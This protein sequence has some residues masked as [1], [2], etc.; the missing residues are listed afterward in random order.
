MRFWILL[1][2]LGWRLRWM[3]FRHK[4]FRQLVHGQDYTMQFRTADNR[5][6]RSYAFRQNRVKVRSGMHHD[7]TTVLTFR[8]ATYAFRTL[9]GMAKNP[10][11]FMEG[12]QKQDIRMTG[13]ASPWQ[14]FMAIL[15]F[16]PNRAQA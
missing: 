16:R 2:I 6:A 5:V 1:L 10:A 13:D 11:L 8:D 3:F 15:S 9:T 7:P 14:S 4:G 12:V